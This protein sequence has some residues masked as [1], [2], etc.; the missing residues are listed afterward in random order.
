AM[1]FARA[2]RW[3]DRVPVPLVEIDRDVLLRR[4]E[5]ALGWNDVETAKA[6]LEKLGPEGPEEIDA[7]RSLAW[8]RL[9]WQS[10]L[11][12]EGTAARAETVALGLRAL[13]MDAPGAKDF[14]AAIIAAS[15]DRVALATIK[16]VAL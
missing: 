14:G 11:A 2:S 8:A 5:C 6:L 13:I 12:T 4:A 7:R 15:R 16:E 10:G 1:D 3:L 9:A